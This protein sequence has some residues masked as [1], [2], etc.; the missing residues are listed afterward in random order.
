MYSMG[1]YE[2]NMLNTAKSRAK[3]L[4]IKKNLT[5]YAFIG[6]NLIGFLILTLFPLLYSFA[7]S[8]M[9][10]NIMRG[11]EDMKFAGFSNYIRMWSDIRFIDSLINSIYFTAVTVILSLTLSLII[12]II[13]NDKVF[14]KSFFRSTLFLP[15]I[16]NMVAIC[17]VWLVIF[18]SSGGVV[19]N[20][21]Q[22]IGIAHPP[23]WL[24][25]PT[26][27][28]PTIMIMYVW[29]NF[30]YN[31]TIYIAGLQGIPNDLYESA[32]IDGANFLVKT[33]KITIPMLSPTTFLLVITDVIF[34][35]QVFAPI[36]IMTKGGPIRSTMTLTYDI[37]Q[38]A[39]MYYDM[40]YASAIAWILFIIILIITLFQFRGQ[41][42]WVNY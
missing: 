25:S 23:E 40:C 29:M 42:K 32:S 9:Q 20:F 17:A 35:F 37:Y 31:L 36:N 27:A 12:S 5:G 4:K 38:T 39:F 21:L 19:N 30:G 22:Q 18:R 24:G 26:W 28:L 11:I 7:L 3:A 8:F 14:F 15:Y 2:I 33:L 34:A 6:S 41:R 16:C 1:N 13:L 10:G